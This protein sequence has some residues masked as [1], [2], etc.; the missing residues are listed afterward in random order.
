MQY[1]T[2]VCAS[3]GR[4]AFIYTDHFVFSRLI[5]YTIGRVLR[6]ELS[7]L[8]TFRALIVMDSERME[9]L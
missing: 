8:V 3:I 6:L 7:D 5:Q 9:S 4:R 2:I 1:I